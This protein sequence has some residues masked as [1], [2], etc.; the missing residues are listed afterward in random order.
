[1]I[2][3]SL[4]FLKDELNSFI[5]YKT[6]IAGKVILCPIVDESGKVIISKDAIGLSLINI[7]EEK[8]LK[9]QTPWQNGSLGTSNPE[10]KINLFILFTANFGD[11][12]ESL[13]FISHVISYFQS[14]SVFEQSKYPRLYEGIEKLVLEL[15]SLSFEQQN[16]LWSTIGT[17]YLPSVLFKVKALVFKE[18]QLSGIETGVSGING[19]LY[20]K[21]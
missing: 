3:K 11:Y 17:K 14:N 1:M 20:N 5:Q 2:D 8:I 6:G 10:I 15:Y 7:D 13:K 16:Q 18:S 12:L 4:L 9:E 19:E 21:S